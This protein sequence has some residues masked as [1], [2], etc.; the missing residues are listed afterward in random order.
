MPTVA[1]LFESVVARSGDH[2]AVIFG[3]RLVSY[4]ELDARANRLARVLV[5][6]G[7]GPDTTVAVAMPKCDE[8]MVVL[9]AVL[10][11]GGA[12]LPLDPQYPAKRLAYM[13][14]DARPTLLVRM[15]QVSLELG[16]PV[17]ELVVDDPD[18][19]RE[20]ESRPDHQLTD[21]S[22]N[23]P[24]RPDNL[25]YVIYTSGSTGTPKG[26]AVTH[27]GVADIVAA[28]TASIAP[29]P[30]D[31]VLQWASVSFD[32][33]FWDWS[34]ALLSGATLIMAPADELL[35]GQPLRDTLRRYAVTHAVLPPVALSV[36]EPDD[37]LVGGTLM[38]TGDACTRALVAKWAPG[39]RM[40]NGYGPTETTVGSTIAGPIATSD[41][42]TIGTPWSGN[43]VY[44]LDERLRPVP[45]GRDGELYLAGNGLARGY[46]NR[47]GL[48]ASR[49]VLDPFG[50]PGGRMYRSGDRGH[51]RAD[52]QLVFASRGDDQVK[53]RGFR[54]ELGEVEARL[55]AHPAVDV[56]AVVVVGDL[57]GARLAAFVST[58]AGAGVSAAELSAHSAET[59]PEHMV[60]SSVQVLQRLPVTA[61]GKIDRAA[62]RDLAESAAHPDAAAPAGPPGDDPTSVES[63]LCLLVRELLAVPDVRPGDNFFKL[64]GHSVLATRLAGRLRDEW[65]IT[66]PIRAVF[67]AATL[68]ELALVVQASNESIPTGRP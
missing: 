65:G 37:V 60:P 8:L 36:T 15:A 41:E 59:L 31:R 4:A 26:V 28:Q 9:L 56:A 18:T 7:V 42:I 43:R 1:E 58:V 20:I 57:A 66:V 17:A 13:V 22:R 21:E 38:S 40:Y 52:G 12:Y 3:D 55:A 62:L 19:A 29:R 68:S 11:A 24:L 45:N 54:V 53:I 16:V 34:A 49:F 10:K 48:T 32:A 30:G 2:V 44:V 46:L 27:T 47:P 6:R 35:P 50:P 39:R 51:R 63:R 64:G 23:A 33:A 25:M 67:E 5:E 14:Q 61:N